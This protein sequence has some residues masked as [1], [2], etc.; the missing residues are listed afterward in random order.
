ML[1]I[2]VTVQS[3]HTVCKIYATA[4]AGS[5]YIKTPRPPPR[6]ATNWLPILFRQSNIL[7]EG[8][9]Y[10]SHANLLGCSEHPSSCALKASKGG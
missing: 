6:S 3:F 1:L 9:N 4:E 10:E 5:G 2:A 7:F 8:F